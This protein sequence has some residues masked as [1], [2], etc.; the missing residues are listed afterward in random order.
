MAT[1]TTIACLLLVGFIV[2]AKATH[3]Q[4][5]EIS[6]LNKLLREKGQ[7]NASLA[8]DLAN[9]YKQNGRK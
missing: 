1:I 3:K 8:R 2:L 4:R 7:E 5:K 9:N 6:R